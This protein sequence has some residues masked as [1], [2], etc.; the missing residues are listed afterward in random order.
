MHFGVFGWSAFVGFIVLML[1]LDLGVFHRRAHDVSF[2]EAAAWS[3]VWVMLSFLFSVGIRIW[4][5]EQAALE[6]VTGYLVEWSLSVDNIFVFVIIFTYFGVPRIYQHRILFWGILGALVMRGIFIALG[7]YVLETWHWVTYVFGGL[8]VLTGIRMALRKLE[9][10]D[11]GKNPVIRIARRFLPL[12]PDY[13]GQRFWVRE[14]GRWVAT[15]LFVALPVIEFT[16]LVFA[17]DSIPAIFAITRDPSIVFTSNV[18]A[19]LGLRSMYFLL[20][21]VVHR[22]VYLKFALAVVLVFIGCKMLLAS[23]IHIP[24]ALSLVVVATLIF[25]AI[26]LSLLVPPRASVEQP[27]SSGPDERG[28]RRAP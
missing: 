5:G 15:P 3:L 28:K 24:T 23:V 19:I 22:F 20:A 7:V 8:L 13:H 27:V 26:W 10:E 2:R 25:G 21:S 4:V 11:F 16:D 1:A 14:N 12:T 9:T 18:F 17:V 6:F